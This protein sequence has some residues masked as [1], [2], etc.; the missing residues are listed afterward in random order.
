MSIE[1][2]HTGYEDNPDR[3]EF[4]RIELPPARAMPTEGR[5]LAE[6]LRAHHEQWEAA[7]KRH[8]ELTSED[9]VRQARRQDAEA[10]GAAVR[11]GKQLPDD[12]HA[13]ALVAAAAAC[14]KEMARHEAAGRLITRDLD[15][16]ISEVAADMA[17]E[18]RGRIADAREAHQQALDALATAR[19]E[20]VAS[21]LV[22]LLLDRGQ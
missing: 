10:L 17:V 3:F 8:R 21:H 18:C 22:L 19:K 5:K 6:E 13:K 15:T 7:S 1:R 20:L 16:T 2:R 14:E 9:A 12:E 4:T 11:A